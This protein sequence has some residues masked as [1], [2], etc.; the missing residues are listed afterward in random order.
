MLTE[1][2]T[3]FDMSGAGFIWWARPTNPGPSSSRAK[4]REDE[5]WQ[6]RF[7][8]HYIRDQDDFNRHCDYIH[9]NPVKHGLV[10]EPKKW[11]YSTIHRFIQKGS[12]TENWGNSLGDEMLSMEV[13]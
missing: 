5:I 3:L 11:E 9:Y 7:W 1:L 13:E 12:Y 8:E 10:D 6:R 2:C 4:H